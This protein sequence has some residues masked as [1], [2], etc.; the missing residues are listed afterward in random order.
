MAA[1]S[2]EY[3]GAAWTELAR[4]FL[5]VGDATGAREYASRSVAADPMNLDGFRLLAVVGRTARNAALAAAALARIAELSAVDHFPRAEAYL[6]SRSPQARQAL[7]NGVR[8]ELPHE[9]FLELAAWYRGVGRLDD[10]RDVLEAAPQD[11]ETLYWLAFVLD[12]LHDPAAAETLHRADAASARLVFPFRSESAPV[13]EWAMKQDGELAPALLPRAHSLG[14]RRH[15]A[16]A[17]PAERGRR[18][19]GLRSPLRCPREA[20]GVV[21]A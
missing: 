9:T 4:L 14:S 17:R 11:G 2:P 19:P 21:V 12:A 16:R 20:G 6:A 3:R 1:Q 18:H 15:E 7:V 5:R 8:N 13:F 10:A